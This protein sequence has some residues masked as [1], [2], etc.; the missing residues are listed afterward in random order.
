MLL[1]R[2]GSKAKRPSHSPRGPQ[3]AKY[4]N[5]ETGATWSGRGPAPAWMANA[6]D[7]AQFLIDVAG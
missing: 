4:R 2:R 5:S 1:R 3:P 7:R 6:K